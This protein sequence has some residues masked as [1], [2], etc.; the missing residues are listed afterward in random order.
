[1]AR[2]NIVNLNKKLYLAEYVIM[3]MVTRTRSHNMYFL[4]FVIIEFRNEYMDW[5][6]NWNMIEWIFLVG[7]HLIEEVCPGSFVKDLIF[8]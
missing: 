6:T 5:K 2:V 3:F 4:G 1:M 7:F 8:E